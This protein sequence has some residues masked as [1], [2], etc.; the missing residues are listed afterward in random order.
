MFEIILGFALQPVTFQHYLEIE[1]EQKA[2]EKIYPDMAFF[3]NSRIS[4]S[5]IPSVFSENI[6]G[7]E[8]AF[9]CG[10]GSQGIAGTYYYLKDILEQYRLKYAVV[11]IDYQ[12]ILKEE[13]VLM[14][15]LLVL[16]RLRNP[17]IKAEFIADVFEPSEYVYFLKS[18]QYRNNIKD[19]PQNLK[20]KFSKG[21]REGIYVGE[22]MVYEELGFTRETSVFGTKA[23]IYISQPWSEENIDWN[24]MAYLD[25]IVELCQRKD[26][27]LFFVSTPLT[28]STVYGTPGYDECVDFFTQYAAM[29]DI[30]Y[31]NLNLLK[32]REEF[33][34]DSMMNCMEHVGDD[35]AEVISDYY[36]QVLNIRIKGEN[37]DSYFFTSV[38]E[39]RKNM[40]DIVACEFKTEKIDENGNRKM[41]GEVLGNAEIK[42]EF[43][44][45]M[46]KDGMIDVL[47]EYRQMKEVILPANKIK[48][49]MILRVRARSARDGSEKVYEVL[50]DET[51]W[52]N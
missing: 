17:L 25:K 12:T 52:N 48:Y 40:K 29:K 7:V 10:T 42:P 51:T 6:D 19:I 14:R 47:Q 32:G 43:Q 38:E 31:D 36:S 34:P 20:I 27:Q 5:F 15:D 1:L 35:R 37:A 49:P 21:Y 46:E 8:L 39:M 2:E 13:R 16:E 50:I 22:G 24:K 44:F 30:P 18:F 28:I 9:N 33:L 45:E 26:V 3:G 4:T 11:G 23:G 41:I